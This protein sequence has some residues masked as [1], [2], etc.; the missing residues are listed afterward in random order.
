LII[1]VFHFSA[2]S[3]EKRNTVIVRE[4]VER[5]QKAKSAARRETPTA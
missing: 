5:L 1:V 3:A 4:L 2:H